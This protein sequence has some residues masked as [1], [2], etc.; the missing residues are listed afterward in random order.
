MG[1]VRGKLLLLIMDDL[2][3]F[4]SAAREQPGCKRNGGHQPAIE[5]K[6]H[7]LQLVQGRSSC[8]YDALFVKTALIL[9][10]LFLLLN[11]ADQH[12]PS[13]SMLHPDI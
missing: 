5:C 4:Q 8:Q 7:E 12:A 6:K 13:D 3:W 11:L 10:V 9:A 1:N 2:D